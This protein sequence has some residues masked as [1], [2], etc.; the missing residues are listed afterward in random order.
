MKI[1]CFLFHDWERERDNTHTH[2]QFHITVNLGSQ[3]LENMAFVFWMWFTLINIMIHNCV[4]FPTKMNNS[5]FNLQIEFHWHKGY[6]LI[7]Y[8]SVGKNLG[9]F[10]H[11]VVLNR[12]ETNIY[13][14]VGTSYVILSPSG[15]CARKCSW[16]LQGPPRR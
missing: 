3:I 7:I 14:Q 6:T 11:L 10:H 2:K 16:T 8:F 4:R 15:V 9:W 12:P 5:F 1:F 13:M